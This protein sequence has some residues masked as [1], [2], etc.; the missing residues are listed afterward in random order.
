MI[1]KADHVLRILEVL[2]KAGQE[3]LNV[4]EHLRFISSSSE[5]MAGQCYLNFGI[6]GLQKLKWR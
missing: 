1:K 6:P 3:V 4:L 5:N 2:A